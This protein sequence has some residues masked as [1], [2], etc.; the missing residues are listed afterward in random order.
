MLFVCSGLEVQAKSN[1]TVYVSVAST[2][3]SHAKTVQGRILVDAPPQAVWQILTDYSE[4]KNRMPGYEQ[5]K[6]LKSAGSVKM[7]DVAMKVG[8]L[9]PT[10]RYQVQAQER[11]TAYQLTF[12]RVSGDF[13]EMTALYRLTP[14]NNG[15]QTVLSYVLNIDVGMPLPGFAGILKSNTEK[16]LAALKRYSELEASRS[17]IGQR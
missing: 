7:L 4:W 5:S 13:D 6:I 12:Q 9:L 16:S 8:A 11:Q 2:P 10:C 17:A 1:G 3:Q 15:R 14:Q